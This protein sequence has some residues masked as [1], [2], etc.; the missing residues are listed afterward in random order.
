MDNLVPI[1]S[2]TGHCWWWLVAS[3]QQEQVD[4]NNVS[5]SGQIQIQTRHRSYNWL[6]F[7]F[8]LLLHCWPSGLAYPALS[9]CASVN[10]FTQTIISKKQQG[11]SYL[12]FNHCWSPSFLYSRLEVKR[13]LQNWST[14]MCGEEGWLGN[15]S[16]STWSTYCVRETPF[17]NI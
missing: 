2:I 1:V 9:A 4:H 5:V 17:I 15:K 3:V 11:I 8:Q 6:Q 13:I 14:L 10:M 7:L 16:L 12:T